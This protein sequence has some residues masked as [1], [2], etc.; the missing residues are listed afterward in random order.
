M[1]TGGIALWDYDH[2]CVKGSQDIQLEKLSRHQER[3][4]ELSARLVRLEERAQ[5]ALVY[6]LEGIICLKRFGLS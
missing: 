1:A 6:E 4:R 5:P 2:S 3:M